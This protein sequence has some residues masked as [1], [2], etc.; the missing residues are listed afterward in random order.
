[1]LTLLPRTLST[2]RLYQCVKSEMEKE[3][4][5]WVGCHPAAMRDLGVIKLHSEAWNKAQDLL[6]TMLGHSLNAGQCQSQKQ[7]VVTAS[8]MALFTASSG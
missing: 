2:A 8:S 5:L 7:R 6:N 3:L 4:H 1:M